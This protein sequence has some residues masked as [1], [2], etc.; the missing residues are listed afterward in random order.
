MPVTAEAKSIIT[1]MRSAGRSDHTIAAALN[2]R[3]IPTP[4]GRKGTMWWPSS[5]DRSMN[6]NVWAAYM[7]G[8]KAEARSD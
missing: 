3:G 2:R 6:P 8:R 5:I 7:R 4:S 1:S